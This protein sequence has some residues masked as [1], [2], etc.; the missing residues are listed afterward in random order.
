MS[1]EIIKLNCPSCGGQLDLPKNLEFAFC[2][3][4]GTKVVLNNVE[5]LREKQHVERYK[6]LLNVALK[7]KNYKEVLE[8]CN[9]ILEIDP[10]DVDSW[11]AKAVASCNLDDETNDVWQEIMEYL[12]TAKR[13]KPN[14]EKIEQIYNDLSKQQAKRYLILSS[15]KLRHGH[16]MIIQG[17]DGKQDNIQAMEYSLRCFKCEPD[18]IRYLE[19]LQPMM[20]AGSIVGIQW[21]NEVYF[22]AKV[23]ENMRAKNAAASKLVQLQSEL[24][25]EI[26]K[27]SSLK[28]SGGL[29][30]DIKL[31]QTEEK[32]RK[33]KEEIISYEKAASYEPPRIKL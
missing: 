19:T 22:W 32:I 4:C 31:K 33:L 7:A 16:D 25:Q 29:F 11:V 28:K 12:R 27:F 10:N 3:Y 1:P 21:G 23:L 6:E 5:L 24:K 15:Q 30:L 13:I 8:Y 18:N 14:E 2:T 26:D 9:K 20:Q 17:M